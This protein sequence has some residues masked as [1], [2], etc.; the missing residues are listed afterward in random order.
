MNFGNLKIL[1]RASV[2]K[3]VSD[4]ISNQVLEL[5]INEGTKDVAFRTK[6]L[7]E[8][9]KFDVVADQYQ[10]VLSD[11]TETVENYLFPDKSGL[12]WNAGSAASPDWQKLSPRTLEWLD[13]NIPNWRAASSSNPK[14]YAVQGENLVLHPTPDT[15]L[16]DGFWFYF[17]KYPSTM[18]AAANYPFMYGT[19][20]MTHLACLSDSIIKYAR[21]K[22]LEM[23][24]AELEIKE[25]TIIAAEKVYKSEVYEKTRML[26]ERPDV[27]AD[28]DVKFMGRRA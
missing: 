28:R 21:Y 12:W 26:M 17:I 23:M 9:S 18:T 20:E 1:S 6:C 27:Q 14:Y 5:I 4:M 8:D 10:Y 11:S 19:S 25:D 7:Q 24:K 13:E 22:M 16:T 2:S 15:S 3:A